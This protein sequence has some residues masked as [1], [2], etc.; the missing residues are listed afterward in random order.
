[1]NTFKVAI[2]HRSYETNPSVSHRGL[3]I[4]AINT[5]KTLN[6][7]GVWAQV[8]SLNSADLLE[9][10]IDLTPGLTHVVIQAPWIPTATLDM[11]ARKHPDVQFAVN[12]HSN[13]GF[14]QTEP[15][16]IK[17]TL[18]LL[19]LE[20]STTN[21]HCSGNSRGFVDWITDAYQAPC[22]LLPNLYYLDATA[23]TPRPLWNGGVLKIGIFGAPR[24]QKNVMTGAAG[25]IQIAQMMKANTQ[26]WFNAGRNETHGKTILQ[27]VQAAIGGNPL[28]SFNL[29]SWNQWPEFRRFVGS[30]N[31]LI[32]CSY[33]E[34]FNQVTADG[35]ATGVPTV[36]SPAIRWSPDYWKADPDSAESIA[37][38]GRM[39][40]G[41]PLSQ[42]DGLEALRT[43]NEMGLLA[44]H[45]YLSGRP[46]KKF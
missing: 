29:F 25:A 8:W 18:E 6:Q 12:C 33:T 45:N 21:I 30:M 22:V 1:M 34:S 14:L 16:A 43:H 39:L 17:L 32:Q 46:F 13:V 19:Q 40:L 26:I 20:Q 4:A 44:W 3:G 42:R 41:N 11:V 35:I 23:D 27:A 2:V 9:K 15:A 37:Q 38:V 28:C 36:T 7:H 24:P 31:L 5:C 10:K